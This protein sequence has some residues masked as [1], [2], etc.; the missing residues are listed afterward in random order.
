MEAWWRVLKDSAGFV[1]YAHIPDTLEGMRQD[2]QLHHMDWTSFYPRHGQSTNEDV[3]ERCGDGM[4]NDDGTSTHPKTKPDPQ[5]YYK[6]LPKS[7]E[8]HYWKSWYDE[9]GYE[10]GQRAF[11]HQEDY[12]DDLHDW[13]NR[14]RCPDGVSPW[15][16]FV[17]QGH[18]QEGQALQDAQYEQYL[19]ET[20]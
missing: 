14:H 11:V 17:E 4:L 16:L 6:R 2:T 20:R 5:D 19:R 18:S 8:S 15:D 13:E 7:R 12:E 1:P 9:V 3:C 10:P